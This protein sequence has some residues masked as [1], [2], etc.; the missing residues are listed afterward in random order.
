LSNIIFEEDNLFKDNNYNRITEISSN[1]TKVYKNNCIYKV[2]TSNY[3][4]IA[5]IHHNFYN[6]LKSTIM[7]EQAYEHFYI[8][9]KLSMLKYLPTVCQNTM[10]SLIFMDKFIKQIFITFV[11]FFVP[12]I[13]GMILS[14]EKYSIAIII[15][16][17]ILAIIYN[18]FFVNFLSYAI[19]GF[20]E[21][22]RRAF[23]SM[24]CV[25]L[26]C[27]YMFMHTGVMVNI[28]GGGNYEIVYDSIFT[29][30]YLK[31]R[32]IVLVDTCTFIKDYFR[33][34]YFSII[35]FTTIGFGD[36]VPITGWAKLLA[37]I[38]A[39]SSIFLINI[40]TATFIRKMIRD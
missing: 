35:T 21:R 32:Y 14:T 9:K 40:F 19:C 12:N 33:C 38:E 34:L 20:G 6:E 3:E 36:V 5:N 26:G 8:Y 10:Y 37:M 13:L 11:I 4:N 27:A 7:K 39:V 2:D 22:P 23:I 25:V 29:H 1:Y 16:V 30:S 28:A 24:S 17:I 15:I 18:R 31:S